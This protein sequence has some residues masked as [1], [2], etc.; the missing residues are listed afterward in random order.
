MTP[1]ELHQE[2]YENN[3]IG[4][5]AS[6]SQETLRFMQEQIEINKQNSAE[7]TDIKLI[8]VRMEGK[9]D[10]IHE[11]TLKTNGRVNKIED[12]KNENCEFIK[13]SKENSK[14][15]RKRLIDYGWKLALLIVLSAFGVQNIEKVIA[16]FK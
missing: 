1:D 13:E 8:L 7:H 11:Q 15:T 6:P 4:N 12:W 5:H 9:I 10:T 14:N 2:Y 3:P 16:V